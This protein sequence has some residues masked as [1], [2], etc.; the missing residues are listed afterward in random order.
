MIELRN[1]RIESVEREEVIKEKVENNYENGNLKLTIKDLED[2]VLIK[3]HEISEL[4]ANLKK[5]KEMFENNLE[6]EIN[7]VG[8]ESKFLKSRVNILEAEL[9]QTRESTLKR[10]L[11]FRHMDNLTDGRRTDI[12]NL[13]HKIQM[14]KERK[15]PACWRGTKCRRMF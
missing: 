14:L 10:S 3:D 7:S 1:L 13:K 5:S 12:D 11:L 2:E 8:K 9:L 4:N 15:F 6:Q